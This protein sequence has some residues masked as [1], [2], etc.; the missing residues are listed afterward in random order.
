MAGKL[1]K[2]LM[3]RMPKGRKMYAHEIAALSDILHTRSLHDMLK[4]ASMRGLIRRSRVNG[5]FVYERR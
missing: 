1:I 3:L 4:R 5:R 2:E